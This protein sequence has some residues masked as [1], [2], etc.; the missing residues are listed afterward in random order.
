[1]LEVLEELAL[2]ITFNVECVER[3]VYAAETLRIHSIFNSVAFRV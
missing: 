1:M 2:S 3:S